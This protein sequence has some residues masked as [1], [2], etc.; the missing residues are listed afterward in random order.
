MK[1]LLSFLL[2]CVAS[3]SFGQ[4][5]VASSEKTTSRLRIIKVTPKAKPKVN[6]VVKKKGF[7]RTSKIILK[8]VYNNKNSNNE[9]SNTGVKRVVRKVYNLNSNKKSAKN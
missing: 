1:Y 8:P 5:E 3:R 2:V 9:N 4:Q 7:T 6:K